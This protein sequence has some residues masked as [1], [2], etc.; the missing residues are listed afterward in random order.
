MKTMKTILAMSLLLSSTAAF[1]KAAR[2]ADSARFELSCSL[3]RLYVD[4]DGKA[5]SENITPAS[6]Q[7]KVVEASEITN[8]EQT[9]MTE[10][11]FIVQT[12]DGAVQVK[13]SADVTD[14]FK[15]QYQIMVTLRTNLLDQQV[16]LPVEMNDTSSTGEN[17]FKHDQR[18][19]K[20]VS[21]QYFGLGQ[22]A[23]NYVSS[24]KVERK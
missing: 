17:T 5:L 7:P 9:P 14:L 2:S 6:V 24:C 1:A 19:I 20:I 4:K 8:G 11:S 15:S 18:Q 22:L 12:P 13:G 23:N 21:N 10:L 16:S 3:E